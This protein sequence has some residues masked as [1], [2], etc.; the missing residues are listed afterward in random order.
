MAWWVCAGEV[1]ASAGSPAGLPGQR[2]AGALCA[3]PARDV[4]AMLGLDDFE[5]DDDD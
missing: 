5:V 2:H 3:L 1:R 4:P